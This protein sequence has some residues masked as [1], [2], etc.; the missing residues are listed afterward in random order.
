M[1]DEQEISRIKREVGSYRN[2]DMLSY[3][4]GMMPW[5]KPIQ[6]TVRRFSEVL[7]KSG[8]THA[9]ISD[10]AVNFYGIPYWSKDIQFAV[11]GVDF[12][13]LTAI[14][15]ES[16]FGK[17]VERSGCLTILDLQMNNFLTICSEPDSLRWDDKM[18]ERI[19]KT[20]ISVK[21]LSPEDYIILLIKHSSLR[22]ID[23]AAKILYIKFETI[24]RDYI[25]WRARTYNVEEELFELIEKLS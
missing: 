25:S 19:S 17:L 21:I 13:R 3:I 8:V 2:I 20:M 14:L 4:D 10:Y 5:M 1:L 12:H 23:L 22:E 6:Y 18:V 15:S 16:F 24:D 11:K 7:E 9:L